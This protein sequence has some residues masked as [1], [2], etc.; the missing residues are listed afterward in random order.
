MS[1]PSKKSEKPRHVLKIVELAQE[2]AIRSIERNSEQFKA[3]NQLAEDAAL[4]FKPIFDLQQDLLNSSFFKSISQMVDEFNRSGQQIAAMVDSV[5]VAQKQ[6]LGMQSS[7]IDVAV[8]S[9]KL[10]VL[11]VPAINSEFER[12]LVP[13]KELKLTYKSAV[14]IFENLYSFNAT[15]SIFFEDLAERFFAP[16][17]IV[18]DFLKNNAD[19]IRRVVETMNSLAKFSID[20][21]LFTP[22]IGFVKPQTS[23]KLE[24]DVLP[25][26][27]LS[28]R[29]WAQENKPYLF[30]PRVGVLEWKLT[31]N[32]ERD[33]D[34]QMISRR[35]EIT[36]ANIY[37]SLTSQ[38]LNTTARLSD[39]LVKNSQQTD[40]QLTTNPASTIEVE[41][42]DNGSFVIHIPGFGSSLPIKK[43]NWI[44]MLKFFAKLK[45]LPKETILKAWNN[46]EKNSFQARKKQYRD[47][48]YVPIII[49]QI[50]EGIAKNFPE[51]K[52]VI[53]IVR[54][55]EVPFKGFYSMCVTNVLAS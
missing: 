28:L 20:F 14:K 31:V 26:N 5:K 32:G 18:S 21:N 37:K 11:S 44:R 9:K 10:L 16:F 2:E 7:L 41:E 34:V 24:K 3:I 17:K 27:N 42:I 12:I 25:S 40:N 6:F 23:N 30:R 15:A 48:S 47:K 1:V 49:R 43:C 45:T 35:E 46:Y 50:H 8:I 13:F 39:I 29:E 4:R 53:R 38:S 19:T 36:D 33:G 54:N 51:A 22:Y 55:K 52:D